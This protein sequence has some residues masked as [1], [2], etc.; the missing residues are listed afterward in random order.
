MLLDVPGEQ[1]CEVV[2]LL[3]GQRRGA[4]EHGLVVGVC[5]GRVHR[6][7][8]EVRHAHARFRGPHHHVAHLKRSVL[9]VQQQVKDSAVAVWLPSHP[10]GSATY[11]RPSTQLAPLSDLAE[12]I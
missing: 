11:P 10:P 12:Q 6:S 2:A 8:E 1:L 7:R 5:L 3:P 9:R 4:R